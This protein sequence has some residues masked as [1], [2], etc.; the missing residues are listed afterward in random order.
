MPN[1]IALVSQVPRDMSGELA[2]LAAWRA[3]D[4]DGAPSAQ[5]DEQGSR[6][7]TESAGLEL[8]R[9]VYYRR[10]VDS[11]SGVMHEAGLLEISLQNFTLTELG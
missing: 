6:A 5:F 3:A 7:C 9:P 4:S 2:R 10:D 8:L 11:P 1:L